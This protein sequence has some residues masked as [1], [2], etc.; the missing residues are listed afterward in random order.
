MIGKIEAADG[1]RNDKLELSLRGQHAGVF[2]I[3]TTGNIYM[4]PDQAPFN[5]TTIHLVAIATDTGNP[6]RSTTVPVTVT[7]E[8][9]TLARTTWASS[10]LGAFTVIFIIFIIIITALSC[11]IFRSKKKRRKN[12]KARNRVHSHAHATVTA[13]TLVAQKKAL[14]SNGGIT[15]SAKRLGSGSGIAGVGTSILKTHPK[16]IANI[17]LSNAMNNGIRHAGSGSS[18]S[19]GASTILAASLEREAQLDRER[20]RHLETYAATVRSMLCYIN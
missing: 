15:T 1:D 17:P 18:L 19:A 5:E 20:D 6:P 13:A 11:Y 10:L 16:H 4:H 3:D 9:V 8:G 7:M 14:S 12:S 2:E